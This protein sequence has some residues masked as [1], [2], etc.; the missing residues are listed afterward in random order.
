MVV[1]LFKFFFMEQLRKNKEFIINYL[2]ALSGVAKSRALIEQYVADEGLIG[3]IVFFEA[4]FPKYEMFADELTAEDNRVIVRARVRGTHLGDLGGIA[5]TYK[6]FELP[7]AIGY[8]IVNNKIVSHW[9]AADQMSLMEQ[10][11]VVPARE[12]TH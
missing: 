4:A 5:P 3:H 6:T 11:G 1:P 10:L 2:N 8:E 7:F 12:A 9:I